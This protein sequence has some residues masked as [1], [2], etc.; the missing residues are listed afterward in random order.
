MKQEQSLVDRLYDRFN[1]HPDFY[2]LTVPL[3][4]PVMV[5]GDKKRG[6]ISEGGAVVGYGLSIVVESCKLFILGIATYGA[7]TEAA[8]FVAG[9]VDGIEKL[10]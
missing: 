6:I 3:S 10:I 8:Q 7:A 2:A 1:T 5:H 4:M 9:V